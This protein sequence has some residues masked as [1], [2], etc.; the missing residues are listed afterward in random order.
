MQYANAMPTGGRQLLYI[1][2][3]LA[4]AMVLVLFLSTAFEQRNV[5]DQSQHTID[6]GEAPPRDVQRRF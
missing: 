1:L 4:G 6:D 5:R 3:A 2:V